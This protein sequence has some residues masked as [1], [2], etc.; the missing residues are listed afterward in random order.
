MDS[1]RYERRNDISVLKS[2]QTLFAS[3]GFVSRREVI[4]AFF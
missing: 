1:R 2:I 4:P 3:L